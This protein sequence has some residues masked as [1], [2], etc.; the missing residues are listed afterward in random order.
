MNVD[1]LTFVLSHYLLLN[2]WVES[3]E[4]GVV[5]DKEMGFGSQS[6]KHARKFDGNV[7]STNDRDL[8]WLLLNFEESIAIGTKIGAGDAFWWLGWVGILFGLTR[9]FPA[10]SI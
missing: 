10:L 2:H 7:S 4:E 1:A 9:R 8:L 5:A 6:M 3:S